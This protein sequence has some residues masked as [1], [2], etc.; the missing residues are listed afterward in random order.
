MGLP[1]LFM[2]K[3]MNNQLRAGPFAHKNL[4]LCTV[5]VHVTLGPLL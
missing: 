3:A 4:V 1:I 2:A 5:H